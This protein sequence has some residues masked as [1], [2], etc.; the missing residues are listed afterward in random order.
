MGGDIGCDPWAASASVPADDA[1]AAGNE[2]WVRL[3][4]VLPP[5]GVRAS[6][7]AAPIPARRFLPR[8]RV[9]LVEDILANQLVTATLLR[10]EG[11]MVDIA[12]NGEAA[13]HAVAMRPYDMVF[14]DIFMPGMSGL[15][16]ARRIRAM[17]PAAGTVPILALTAN[18]SSDDQAMCREAGMNGLLAKPVALPELLDALAS[19]VWANSAVAYPAT[20][21]AAW[22]RS[23]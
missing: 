3:P 1:H 9:L 15:E 12:G 22:S 13:L 21:W 10:R 23:A 16:V 18:V 20:C 6:P 19:R 8:T 11:H 17:P 7:A 2:F 14:M 4:I 5:E